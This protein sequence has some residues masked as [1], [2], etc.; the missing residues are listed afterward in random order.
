[1]ADRSISAV[2]R[3]HDA[4]VE[5]IRNGLLVRAGELV[6]P[7]LAAERANNLAQQVIEVFHWWMDDPTEPL[8][9]KEVG[10]G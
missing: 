9:S 10:R 3:L 7:E 4:L 6:T 8:R 5:H 1:M 2:S